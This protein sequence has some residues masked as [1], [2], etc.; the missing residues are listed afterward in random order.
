MQCK[1][2]KKNGERCTRSAVEGTEYCWQHQ[3]PKEESS[4][5]FIHEAFT[6][7]YVTQIEAS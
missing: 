4:E 1:A 7:P 3:P 2:I 6:K 5:T